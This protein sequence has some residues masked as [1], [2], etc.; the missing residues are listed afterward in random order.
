VGA[1]LAR[2]RDT[3]WGAGAQV[4]GQCPSPTAQVLLALGT[5]RRPALALVREGRGANYTA[6]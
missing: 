5:G 6:F 2:V 4:E 3:A 1:A